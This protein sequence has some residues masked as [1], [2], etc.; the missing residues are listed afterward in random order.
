MNLPTSQILLSLL[1]L[2]GLLAI[3]WVYLL[4]KRQ[5]GH[6]DMLWALAIAGQA[7]CYASLADGWTP[8]RFVVALVAS[9]WALRL[10]FHL[11]KRLGRDGEDGRYLAMEAAAGAR[12]PMFFFGFFQLQALAAWL[13]AIPFATLVQDAEPGWRTWEVVALAL[14]FVSLL[15]NGLADRQLDRW[16]RNPIHRGKTC[17]AGLWNW[18]R[19]PNYF[20]E[21]LLWCAYPVA[22]IGTPYLLLNI[23]IAGFMFLM[24]TKVSG[25][26]FTE[27]QALRSRGDDYRAYQDSTSA[28]F[29]LPPKNVTDH[30]SR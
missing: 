11:A 3:A 1:A 21:W 24:V 13:F 20:F 8:R 14:W 17:R 5:L 7:I 27:Q 28:F 15:G 10:S 16:R 22:A 26:P 18:S 2:S 29:L 12:A 4:R 6:V 23:G 9:I 30:P 19:H 25:I